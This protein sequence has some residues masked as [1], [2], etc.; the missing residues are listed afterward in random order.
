MI[1]GFCDSAEGARRTA[2]G[3][4]TPPP[5]I[6][7][8]LDLITATVGCLCLTA[9]AT[10]TR[11]PIALRIFSAPIEV[12][13][14]ADCATTVRCCGTREESAL[15][16][17]ERGWIRELVPKLD[18]VPSPLEGSGCSISKCKLALHIGHLCA[19]VGRGY[20]WPV[21]YRLVLAAATLAILS[22]QD[23]CT[24]WPHGRRTVSCGV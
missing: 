8:K 10:R 7:L 16:I 5:R 19:A 17:K 23:E 13:E 14:R 1:G 3:D 22:T 18:C 20:M 11:A 12:A 2:A 9:K 4:S 6:A 21:R 15:L 24:K